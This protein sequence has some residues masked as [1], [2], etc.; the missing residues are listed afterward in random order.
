MSHKTT[1]GAEAIHPVAFVS[2]TD[3]SLDS[4]NHVTARKQ[5]FDTTVNRMKVRNEDNDDWIFVGGE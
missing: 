3:P 5:W 4:D 1:T 2:D